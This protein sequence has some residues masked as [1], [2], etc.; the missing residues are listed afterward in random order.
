MHRRNPEADAP[1]DTGVASS[2]DTGG[3]PNPDHPDQHTTTGTTPNDEFVGRVSGE[4]A[5]YEEETGAERRAR[6][7]DDREP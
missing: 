4:D 3:K 7:E 1:L 2:R 5:G 6:A